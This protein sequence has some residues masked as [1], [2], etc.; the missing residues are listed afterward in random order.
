MQRRW[1]RWKLYFGLLVFMIVIMGGLIVWGAGL[2]G[3]S[4]VLGSGTITLLIVMPIIYLVIP[5]VIMHRQFKRHRRVMGLVPNSGGRLCPICL[6]TVNPGEDDKLLCEQC[7]RS[8]ETALLAEYWENFA[9]DS[10]AAA[11]WYATYKA[12]GAGGWSRWRA[13]QKRKIAENPYYAIIYF[14]VI[15]VLAGMVLSLFRSQ[16]LI[17][18]AFQYLYMMFIMSGFLLIGFGQMKRKG[19]SARCSECEYM[20]PPLGGLP[21]VCPECGADWSQVGG[22][23][24]GERIR[25]TK[26]VVAGVTC[27]AIGA[28]LM[29]TPFFGATWKYSLLPTSSLIKNITNTGGFTYD[30]WIVLNTR[31]L[32]PT[33]SLNLA[34]GLLDKRVSRGHFSNDADDWFV[35]R[36]TAGTLPADLVD[37]Y[38]LEYLELRI[39][40]PSSAIVGRR[41][42]I[43]FESSYRQGNAFV[44]PGPSTIFGEIM[45]DERPIEGT[46]AERVVAGVSMD[47]TNVPSFELLVDEVGDIRITRDVWIVFAPLNAFSGKVVWQSDGTPLIP[48]GLAWS[49]QITLEHVIEVGE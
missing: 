18:G 16:S 33:Q 39:D 6:V 48:P 40:A 43:G 41:I 21:E 22:L 42:S 11:V 29:F 14:V 46:R 47:A 10:G 28:M 23:V 30:E 9:M 5:F 24:K 17:A 19:R 31:T 4:G 26:H 34:T 35:A 49:R 45:T 2:V 25:T 38:Y 7:G 37:R 27:I 20:S 44:N 1:L 13:F 36:I 3:G 15:F 12:Q 8:A 32:S